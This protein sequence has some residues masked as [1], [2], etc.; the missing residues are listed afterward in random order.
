MFYKRC[1]D[2]L[3]AICKNSVSEERW[4]FNGIAGLIRP[5]G[6]LLHLTCFP[7]GAHT[8]Y[9]RFAKIVFPRNAD[10]FN[11]IGGLIQPN[12]W[13]LHLTC[14]PKGAQTNYKQF[15][16]IA[17]RRTLNVQRTLWSNLDAPLTSA[18]YMF[19]NRCADEFQ[20]ICEKNLSEER[21]IFNGICGLIRPRGWLASAP[22]VHNFSNRC[23][24]ELAICKNGLS[25]ERCIFNWICGLI[26]PRSWLLHPTGFPIGARTNYKRFVKL[27][28][29]RNAE[30][31]AELVV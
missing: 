2:E 7:K 13:L 29:P 14:F 18:P 5:R 8:N 17:F 9:K 26:R 12:D 20:A 30:F 25:E 1:A 11:G 15:V 3:Q 28:F 6:W 22:H 27:V 31:S 4:I 16:K 24:N 10:F 23:A 19:S 21:W